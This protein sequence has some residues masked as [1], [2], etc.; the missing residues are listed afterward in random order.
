MS[1]DPPME[2]VYALVCKMAI[3]EGPL[4]A[5][6][7]FLEDFASQQLSRHSRQ[8]IQKRGTP[9]PKAAHGT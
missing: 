5:Y 7:S 1:I 4:N 6:M 3:L 8:G 9:H 2:V